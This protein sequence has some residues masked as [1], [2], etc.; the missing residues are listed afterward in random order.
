MLITLF[1]VKDKRYYLAL[2][3]YYLDPD[4]N[5]KSPV[6]LHCA[7]CKR[8]IKSTQSFESFYPIILHPINPWYRIAK[9]FEKST[10]LIGSNCHDKMIAE[11]G[12]QYES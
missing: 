3:W 12:E 2:M 4:N 6:G 8:S 1:G 9:P 11:H 5:K 10:Q 7:R